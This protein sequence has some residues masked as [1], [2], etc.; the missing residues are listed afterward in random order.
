MKSIIRKSSRHTTSKK[1][2]GDLQWAEFELRREVIR[3]LL[4]LLWFLVLAF[5]VLVGA[6]RIK[7][8]DAAI[9]VVVSGVIGC[10]GTIITIV[11]KSW[12]KPKD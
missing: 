4:V 12:L 2:D 8:T 10:V 7:I 11:I 9:G 3:S 5:F 6:G 1:P